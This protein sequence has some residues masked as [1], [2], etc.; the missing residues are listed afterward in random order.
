[1]DC[2]ICLDVNVIGPNCIAVDS[3]QWLKF[4]ITNIIKKYLWPLE[5]IHSLSCICSDCWRELNGFH[6]FYTRVENAHN[7]KPLFLKP[8]IDPLIE[9]RDR[10]DFCVLE[11]EI[12]IDSHPQIKVECGE[13]SGNDCKSNEKKNENIAVQTW[14]APAL[15]DED[16]NSDN[17]SHNDIDSQNDTESTINPNNDVLE[18]NQNE[19]ESHNKSNLEENKFSRTRL[20]KK[21]NKIDN[22][23]IPKMELSEYDEF[24]KK[25]FEMK[26]AFCQ[27]KFDEFRS[28]CNHY[29][30]AHNEQGYALCCDKKFFRRP[31]LID[32]INY[33]LN[34]EYFKCNICGKCWNN[35]QRLH[36]HLRIHG[37]RDFSCDICGKKFV[38]GRHLETHKLVHVPESEKNFPC[39]ECGKFY[40]NEVALSRHKNSVHLNIYTKV[41]DICGQI[42]PDASTFKTHMERH[43]GISVKCDECGLILANKRCL[44]LHKQR[45]HPVDGKRDYN[46][47]ICSRV[48]P[49]L[50]ALKKHIHEVHETD[51]KFTCTI[52]GKGFKRSDNFKSHMSTHTGSPL[53]RCPWCPRAFNSNGNMHKHR[54][55]VHFVEWEKEQ[56][57][58]YSGNLPPKYEAQCKS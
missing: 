56:R 36:N 42:L 40:A 14:T 41:C 24:L 44:T 23:C 7:N 57:K 18:T 20:T 26:C 39:N 3:E 12:D 25:H 54:K 21:V 50:K 19:R 22:P 46:C 49:T 45:K 58:K 11:P 27:Q 32:H 13:V 4:N 48:S 28:L 10:Y 53:Y 1:M 52:C 33:H 6:E 30:S 35:R 38:E 16:Q 2:L 17:E 51:Y 8:E 15:M 47:H 34:P 29:S 55:T 31:H 43:A 9:D 5:P 37:E